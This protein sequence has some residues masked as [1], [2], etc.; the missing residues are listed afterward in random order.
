MRSYLRTA[1]PPL[2]CLVSAVLAYAQAPIHVQ[3]NDPRPLKTAIDQVESALGVPI[4]YEDPRFEYVGDVQDV[5]EQVQSARQHAANPTVR[6]I[7]PRG[8][9]LALDSTPLPQ[10]A[11]I[12]DVLSFVTQ[13]RTACEASNFPGR[14]LAKQVGSTVVVEPTAIRAADGNWKSV[15]PAMETRI[16]FPTQ[17]RN[18]AET[19]KLVAAKASQALGIKVGVGRLPVLSFVST[20]VSVG[21]NDEPANVVLDRLLGQLTAF[22]SA[23]V[24]SVPSYSYRLL[25]DPGV[26]YYLLHI[27]AVSPRKNGEAGPAPIRGPT[28]PSEGTRL[29]VKKGK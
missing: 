24:P 3:V 13:L 8:G 27:I 9:A 14:F 28:Q 16:T 7:V 1:R 12:S 18:A 22:N 26:K 20:S 11:L 10:P 6:I 2:V 15:E 17:Q 5:T 21:A 29:G 19:L 23:G 25:Y 4:N